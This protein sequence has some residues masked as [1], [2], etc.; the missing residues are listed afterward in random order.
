MNEILPIGAGSALALIGIAGVAVGLRRR[1]RRR[2]E[3]AAEDEWAADDQTAVY[4]EEPAIESGPVA[5]PEVLGTAAAA[6]MAAARPEPRHDPVRDDAPVTALPSGFDLSRFG[7]HVQ[8]AYRGPTD[9]NPSLSLRHR[10]RRAAAMD[11]R[12]RRDGGFM[13]RD[14]DRTEAEVSRE[15]SD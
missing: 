9:D 5:E 15:Y 8:A 6:P 3:W 12:E 13:L 1:R 4:D 7:P 11:Q 14:E 10:L 2:D